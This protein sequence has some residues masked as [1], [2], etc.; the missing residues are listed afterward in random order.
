[1]YSCR[2]T[3]VYT[4][5]CIFPLAEHALAE[6]PACWL[7][8]PPL[9]TDGL[10]ARVRRRGPT[11]ILC[12]PQKA[13]DILKSRPDFESPAQLETT[14]RFDGL[15]QKQFAL[16]QNKYIKKDSANCDAPRAHSHRGS[17]G[18]QPCARN[19]DHM[20]THFTRHKN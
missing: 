12:P 19:L 7:M 6:P 4:E 8:P 11:S 14:Y 3:A 17:A 10:G 1:M 20:R 18:V 2:F 15:L 16:Y 9:A 5:C 13:T